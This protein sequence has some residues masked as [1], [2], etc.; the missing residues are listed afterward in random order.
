MLRASVLLTASGS[1]A[2][3][4]ATVRVAVPVDALDIV[5]ATAD[6]GSCAATAAGV[7]CALGDLA[8]GT[9]R[10]LELE[11]R[12]LSAGAA[13]IEASLTADND[14]DSSNDRASATVS[15]AAVASTSSGGQS[16]RR[17]GG[18]AADQALL[19]AL[20]GLAVARCLARARTRLPTP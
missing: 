17:G 13:T 10:R 1:V 3:A 7:T 19:I 12:G 8:A 18:G 5:A 11:L 15:V 2:L 6:Q 9:T 14:G 20:L 4:G 16:G